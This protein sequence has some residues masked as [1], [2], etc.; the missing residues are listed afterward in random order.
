[1]P[2]RTL[3]KGLALLL[4]VAPGV[5]VADKTISNEAEIRIELDV[6]HEFTTDRCQARLEVEWYQKG[7]SVR[8]ESTLTN[9]DCDA[10]SGSHVV[11]VS[12]RG[13]DGERQQ[14]EFEESWQR[15]D[16]E[17][18]RMKKDYF[19]AD[20][21]DVLRVRPGRLRCVCATPPDVPAEPAAEAP[22]GQ[23]VE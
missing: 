2:S 1:M 18:V 16:S 21:V 23:P 13:A 3:T 9:D 22:S 11:R 4:C 15:D 12:Y 10:S 17:P 14:K 19:I 20:D 5:V 7:P 6:K 8:V